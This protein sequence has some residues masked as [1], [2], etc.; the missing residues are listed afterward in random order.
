M[1]LYEI[2]KA[3]L[4]LVDPDTGEVTDFEELDNLAMERD[5]KI[6]NIACY[7]KNIVSDVAALK[8]EEEALAGRRKVAENKANRLKEYLS[9]VLHGEKF[10]TSK[11]QVSFRNTASVVVRDAAAAVEWAELNGHAECVRY[12]APE[13]SKTE[14]GKV[15]KSG[16]DVPGA[17]LVSGLS[18]GVK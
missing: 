14:L 17:E 3:I 2:D 9:Y 18:V 11:C 4:S 13:I 16:V 15:L 1:T 7:Y 5:K 10:Q 8:A 12:K 6:E